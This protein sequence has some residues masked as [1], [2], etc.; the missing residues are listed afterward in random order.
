MTTENFLG[1]TE[2][3]ADIPFDRHMTGFDK[4]KYMGGHGGIGSRFGARNGGPYSSDNRGFIQS[5][6]HLY[7]IGDPALSYDWNPAFRPESITRQL[8]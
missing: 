6:T 2:L 3:P 1:N 5:A 7:C 8:L 4:L